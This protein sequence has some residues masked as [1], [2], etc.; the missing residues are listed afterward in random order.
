MAHEADLLRLRLM[1]DAV[2]RL[3]IRVAT[4]GD[5]TTSKVRATSDEI[6]VPPIGAAGIPTGSTSN[7]AQIGTAQAAAALAPF[8]RAIASP[9]AR[10]SLAI[11][12]RRKLAFRQ[13]PGMPANFSR[14]LR[15]STLLLTG[16][17]GSIL[18]REKRAANALGFRQPALAVG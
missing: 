5:G 6:V 8:P 1:P 15:S 9:S 13:A 7:L 18:H 17:D 12:D 2:R 14:S 11:T 10:S 4:V 3:G 16:S